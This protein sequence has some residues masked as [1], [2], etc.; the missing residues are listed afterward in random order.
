MLIQYRVTR[1]DRESLLDVGQIGDTLVVS[2]AS[3]QRACFGTPWPTVADV[4]FL[5]NDLRLGIQDPFARAERSAS[6]RS[7]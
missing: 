5:R 1:S 4:A 7:A 3:A 6:T 2:V